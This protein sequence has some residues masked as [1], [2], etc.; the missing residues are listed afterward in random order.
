MMK[1]KYFIY[2]FTLSFLF[3]SACRLKDAQVTPVGKPIEYSGPSLLIRK[4]LDSTNLTIYKAIWKKVNM[5]S[6]IDAG[7]YQ[8]YTLLAPSD[9]AFTKAGITADKVNSIPVEQL[10]TLLLYHVLDT[11]LS[12]IQLK[13]LNGSNNMKSLLRR[14]DY[15]GY[16]SNNPF[17][18]YQYLGLHGGKLMVNGKPHPLN[19]LEATNGTIY[20]LDEVLKKP[21]QDM[22][23]YL[24]SNPDFFYFMESV[25]IN[26]SIYKTSWANPQLTRL[27]QTTSDHRS[28][29][30]FAPTNRAFQQSG[31]KT[32][33]D[34]RQ[35][36]LLYPVDWAHYD[37]NNYYVYPTTSMD[38]VLSA[39]HLDYNGG[40]RVN[41]PLVLFSNDLTDNPSLSGFQISPGSQYHEG[42][43]FIR[44][45]FTSSNGAI[46]V[47]QTGSAL[48]ARKLV[49][50]DLLLRNGVIHVI[51]DGLFMP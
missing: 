7:G 39:N 17:I 3:L 12:S 16:Y 22:Y 44:L 10:D 14:I 43:Q 37:N 48:P 41:Y 29:T 19:A 28:F 18:Y 23:E 33:D 1:R 50:T 20:I 40:M 5:D 36:A 45:N 27:L 32:V 35:R 21:E 8:A 42:P 15:P 49:T 2:T 26:D 6:V 4:L 46:M 13:Q 38:T 24:G 25:R 30:L 51:D 9:D 11:W 31:F 34:I 47:K